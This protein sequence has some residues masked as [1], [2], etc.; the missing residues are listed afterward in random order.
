MRSFFI[1]SRKSHHIHHKQFFVNFCWALFLVQD[2][3]IT[4]ITITVAAHVEIVDSKVG[5]RIILGARH[6]NDDFFGILAAVV[7]RVYDI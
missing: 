6:D 1:S 7:F 2:Y 5:K 4:I 3:N